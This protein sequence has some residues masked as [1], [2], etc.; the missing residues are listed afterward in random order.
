MRFMV[1]YMLL[2]NLTL[3]T[4]HSKYSLPL[5]YESLSALY[6]SP[7]CHDFSKFKRDKTIIYANNTSILKMGISLEE[8]KIATSTNTKQI[9]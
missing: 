6:F 9:T 4:E 8:L 7:E 3:Q 1:S 2:L 5:N